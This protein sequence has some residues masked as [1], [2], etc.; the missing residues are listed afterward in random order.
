MLTTP[1][2]LIHKDGKLDEILC[3]VCGTSI[4]RTTE[5]GFKRGT[6]YAEAALDMSDRG[7]HITCLCRLCL[8]DIVE[9]HVVLQEIYDADIA[10]MVRE[11]PAMASQAGRRVVRVRSADFLQRGIP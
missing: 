3:K 10:E 8:L 1:D 6:N 7:R 2:Y 5:E 4:A 9:D 11:V